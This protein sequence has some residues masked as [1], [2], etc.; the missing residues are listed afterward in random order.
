VATR[1]DQLQGHPQTTGTHKSKITIARV[2]GSFHRPF[3]MAA[4]SATFAALPLRRESGSTRFISVSMKFDSLYLEKA[5][6]G[7]SPTITCC[8]GSSWIKRGF[9]VNPSA[10][11]L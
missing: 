8:N 3:C 4:G 1:S 9:S 7:Y 11:V 5:L 2:F 6:E 10:R